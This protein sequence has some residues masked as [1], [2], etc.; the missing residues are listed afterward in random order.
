VLALQRFGSDRRLSGPV[1]LPEWEDA[2]WEAGWLILKAESSGDVALERVLATRAAASITAALVAE[3]DGLIDAYG[4]ARRVAEERLAAAGQPLRHEFRTV[5]QP[6]RGPR[7]AVATGLFVAALTV[8]TVVAGVSI[9]R[10]TF[11]TGTPG[12]SSET[13]QR[14]GGVLGTSQAQ[15]TPAPSAH[16]PALVAMLDFDLLRIG[17]LEGASDDVA[18]VIGH[19][20][21]AS[22]P[23]PFD[24]SI[25]FSGTGPN[26]FCL[27]NDHLGAG[28]ASVTVD[29]WKEMVPSGSKVRNRGRGDR[30]ACG[31]RGG[32]NG[33]QPA[34]RG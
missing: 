1:T 23:S 21:V 15:E 19:A 4:E 8:T 13:D 34:L 11:L 30:N 27:A 31:H 32:Y 20:D 33:R 24:R 26:G 25:R 16:V 29:R 22:F 12:S 5:L 9:L 28:G 18:G 14:A 10:T 2:W 3:L 7:L 17:P 6:V